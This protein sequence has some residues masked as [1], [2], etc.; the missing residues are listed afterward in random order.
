[1]RVRGSWWRSLAP[2]AGLWVALASQGG[3]LAGCSGTSSTVTLDD[4]GTGGPDGRG[5]SGSSSGS[6]AGEGGSDATA[7]DDG[8]PGDAAGDAAGEAGD[9]TAGDDGS[10]GSSGSSGADGSSSGG[11][12]AGTGSGAGGG[13]EGGVAGCPAVGMA[14]TNPAGVCCPAAGGGN[15]CVSGDCCSNAQ[16]SGA[17]PACN[18]ANRTCVAWDPPDGQAVFVDPANGVDAPTGGSYSA[19]TTNAACA[20][21]TITY[22]LAHLGTATAVRVIAT[23]PVG[24]AS[25]EHFPITVP[26]GVTIIGIAGKPVI[27]VPAPAAAGAQSGSAFVMASNRAE[28]DNLVVDGTMAATHGILATGGSTL[29]SS[30]SA[31]EIRNFTAAGIRVD[32]TAQLTINAGTNVH[33]NGISGDELSGLHATGNAHVAIVGV[34]GTPIAFTANGQDGILVDGSASVTI[35]G[36]AGATSVVSNQNKLSGMQV[37]Q[38]TGS[39]FLPLTT[40]TGLGASGNTRAGLLVFG[41]SR[42]TVR[43]SAFVGNTQSGVEVTTDAATAGGGMGMGG[44]GNDVSQIDLGVAGDPGHNTLQSGATPNLGAGLCFNLQVNRGETLR[45]R[46]N[47]WGM[48]DCSAMGGTL[49]TNGGGRACARGVDLGG[50]GFSAF[51]NNNSNAVDVQM[52]NCGGFNNVC[53]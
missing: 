30:V 47:V 26:A 10:S 44:A 15:A 28:I 45:A 24:T 18:A 23:G 52:C 16:C 21:R 13:G 38:D 11:G 50:T 14:C 31:V 46:G 29:A 37:H 19:G 1:M 22:A 48:L 27:D 17:T 43:S 25:G 35:T 34:A 40:I 3:T 39:N 53:Q 8:A 51:V 36:A 20:F 9:S 7:G 12:E 5:G 33:D 32:G 42:V 6:A 4:A 2:V 49:S 41:G